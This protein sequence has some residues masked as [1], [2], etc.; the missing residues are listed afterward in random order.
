MGSGCSHGYQA[1]SPKE[2]ALAFLCEPCQVP[3]QLTARQSIR[4]TNL[5]YSHVHDLWH[6][7]LPHPP[8]PPAAPVMPASLHTLGPVGT[9][10]LRTSQWSSLLQDILRTA[11][12]VT[13]PIRPHLHHRQ[14]ATEATLCL[15]PSQGG[16][17]ATYDNTHKRAILTPPPPTMPLACR[18]LPDLCFSDP[19]V[20]LSDIPASALAAQPSI[21]TGNLRL[22]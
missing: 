15:V 5:E 16:K 6:H 20:T 12:H 19:T 14:P 13:C 4:I 9:S 3:L 11:V 18:A 1:T 17:W 7:L 2:C 21:N 22:D 8:W 10:Y